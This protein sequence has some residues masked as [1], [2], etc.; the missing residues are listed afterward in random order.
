MAMALASASSLMDN[1]KY[2][3]TWLVARCIIS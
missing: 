2:L 3:Y 1:T